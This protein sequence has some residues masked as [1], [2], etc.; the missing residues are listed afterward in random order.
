MFSAK[1]PMIVN[2]DIR[3][4][5]P[6]AEL[7]DVDNHPQE[8]SEELEEPMQDDNDRLILCLCNGFCSRP[9]QT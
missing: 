7:M 4:S 1:A 8:A 6:P 5:P 3:T 2:K 9:P